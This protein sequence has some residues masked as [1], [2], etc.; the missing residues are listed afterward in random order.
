[1]AYKRVNWENLP[2]TNTPVNADNLNKMDEGIANAVEQPTGWKDASL[3]SYLRG[4]ARYVKIGNIVI[5]NFNEVSINQSITQEHAV[6]ATGLPKA[7]DGE[8]R[9]L[10][11]LNT[12]AH[13][14]IAIT[15]AGNIQSQWSY[16]DASNDVWYGTFI[17]VTNQ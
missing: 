14:R 8:L 4:T 6:L 11:N 1:M 9:L 7:S 10:T 2:S 12:G 16:A 13:L 17:Y 5:V 15:D 3:T